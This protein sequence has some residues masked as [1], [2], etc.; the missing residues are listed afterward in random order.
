MI[1]FVIFAFGLTV[2]LV[3]AKGL[4]QARDYAANE[5]AKQGLTPAEKVAGN[6]E[7]DNEF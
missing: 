1:L 7:S 6:E 4:M 5:F 2:S 3:V